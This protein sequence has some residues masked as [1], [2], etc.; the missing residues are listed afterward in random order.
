[1][2]KH[3]GRG[4]TRHRSHA[5]VL[6]TR[7]EGDLPGSRQFSRLV[8]IFRQSFEHQRSGDRAFHR[9]AHFFPGDRRPGVKNGF[10]RHARHHVNRLI[11]TNQH[12]MRLDNTLQRLLVSGGDF[13]RQRRIGNVIQRLH[14]LHI[15]LPRRRPVELSHFYMLLFQVIAK[16]GDADVNNVQWLAKQ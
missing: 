14:H 3:R 7:R 5:V 13:V 10:R 4:N 15:A 12:R 16:H 1:M 2:H 6:V 11:K 8:E 9:A